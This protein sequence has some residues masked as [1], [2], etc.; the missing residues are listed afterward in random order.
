MPSRS[1]E[2]ALDE[3]YAAKPEEFVA[4]RTALAKQ[5]GKTD[6]ATL[7]KQKK[8]TQTAYALNQLARRHPDA[9]AELVDAGK[10]LARAQRRARRGGA[11]AVHEAIARQRAVIQKRMGEVA[12]LA[13]ELGVA[14]AHLPAIAG[15]LRA[16]LV[17]P[18]VGERLE[19]GR[20]VQPPEPPSGFPLVALGSPPTTK[21][22]PDR[23]AA[24]AAKKRAAAKKKALAEA[25]RLEARAEHFTRQADA[26]AGRARD[27]R[28][29]A[30]AL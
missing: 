27:L 3:L 6:A 18:A 22:R 23:A 1:L 16:A 15:A 25:E 21:P 28:R 7:K 30:E 20:L 14:E 26:L 19:E 29:R 12:A 4:R 2:A 10:D 17:D 24:A 8:P 13:G 5:L 11:A 9:I